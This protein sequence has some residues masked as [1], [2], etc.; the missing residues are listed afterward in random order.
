M[1]KCQNGKTKHRKSTRDKKRKSKRK[2][3][4]ER[5]KMTRQILRHR[6]N[7]PEP[8][9]GYNVQRPPMHDALFFL[10]GVLPMS[11][12]LST[13]YCDRDASRLR[14]HPRPPPPP[15]TRT[16]PYPSFRFS[17]CRRWSYNAIAPRRFSRRCSR[18]WS[19]QNT[20]KPW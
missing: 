17:V 12:H 20:R 6:Q 14:L 3:Q 18:P 5:K 10:Y 4:K 11:L 1:Y 2:R 7:C 15:R 19:P 16:L 8:P 13:L 9:G